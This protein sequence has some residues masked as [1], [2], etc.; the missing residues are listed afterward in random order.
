MAED[1]R[2]GDADSDDYRYYGPF[3][4]PPERGSS[5]AADSGDPDRTAPLGIGRW[6]YGDEELTTELPAQPASRA[7]DE[8][9]MLPPPGTPPQGPESIGPTF[10]GGYDSVGASS[11][12]TPPP[13]SS[14]YAQRPQPG[15]EWNASL[16]PAPSGVIPLRPQSPEQMAPS[17]PPPKRERKPLRVLPLLLLATLLAVL[18]G[19]VAGYGG[20][21]LAARTDVVPQTSTSAPPAPSSSAPSS[22]F[23]PV[24]GQQNTVE[25]AKAVLPSTVMIQVG[26]GTSG[27][28]GSGFVL[29]DEGHIMTNNH[30]VAAASDGGQI[31]VVYS[32]GTQT[33]AELVGRS[34]SYDIA[35]IKVE[36]GSKLKPI[37]IGDSDTSQVGESVIA[38]GSPLGLPGTVTAGIVSAKNRPVVVTGSENADAP[39]AYINGIQTDAPIN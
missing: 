15:P 35:V 16:F 2:P 14:P 34:P 31:R 10:R 5:S 33:K 11:Y 6:S 28:T 8:T 25:V 23:S 13:P 7:A 32:D 12:G 22:T 21:R 26:S 20:S 19:G 9:R 24:P 18:V 37:R 29:D 1:D 39:S 30:V 27:G 38:I 36:A 17:F 4:A 3:G